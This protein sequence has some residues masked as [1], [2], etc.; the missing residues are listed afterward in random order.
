MVNTILINNINKHFIHII[1]K[2]KEG[3]MNKHCT[4]KHT[5]THTHTHE[6]TNQLWENN[7]YKSTLQ[8]CMLMLCVFVCMMLAC[9]LNYIYIFVVH[10][11]CFIQ[12]TYRTVCFVYIHQM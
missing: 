11:I 7:N 10:I 2:Q 9:I 12:I 1:T 4:I 5:H 6:R 3:E 8:M